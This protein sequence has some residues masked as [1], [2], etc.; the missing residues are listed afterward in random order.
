MGE[1]NPAPGSREDIVIVSA[2]PQGTATVLICLWAY[3]CFG[4]KTMIVFLSVVDGDSH[5][6]SQILKAWAKLALSTK[7]YVPSHRAGGMEPP[8]THQ[9]PRPHYRGHHLPHKDE[10]VSWVPSLPETRGLGVCSVPP[11]PRGATAL[12]PRVITPET[13]AVMA[14]HRCLG[15]QGPRG[16]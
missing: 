14:V 3:P 10:A 15:G 12:P 16:A 7:R 11:G 5:G 2:D 1:D 8:V 4:P 6:W 9:V 13:E